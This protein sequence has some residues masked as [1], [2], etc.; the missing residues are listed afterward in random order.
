MY[1]PCRTVLLAKRAYD[2]SVNEGVFVKRLLIT[3]AC[4]LVKK[5]TLVQWK[6]QTNSFVAYSATK[7]GQYVIHVALK[8]TS[9]QE[10]IT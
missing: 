7:R 10:L 5:V 6:R 4:R 8:W 9:I 1:K 2:R 3:A